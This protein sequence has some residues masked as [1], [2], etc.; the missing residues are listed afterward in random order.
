R[1]ATTAFRSPT[2]ST[3]TPRCRSS[4]GEWPCYGR[5]RRGGLPADWSA[6]G[7][8]GVVAAGG[9]RHHVGGAVRH[10]VERDMPVVAGAPVDAVRG[11]L[12]AGERP[13]R[14]EPAAAGVLDAGEHL[15]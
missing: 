14:R 2:L 6:V 12:A 10:Q 11:V 13:V 9:G 5:C 7:V 15:V 8:A 4:S 3:R 1:T